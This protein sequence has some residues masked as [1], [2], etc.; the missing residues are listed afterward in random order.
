MSFIPCVPGAHGRGHRQASPAGPTMA[1]AADLSCPVSVTCDSWNFVLY[2][3]SNVGRAAQVH[4]RDRTAQGQ[5]SSTRAL[6][7]TAEHGCQRERA[8][9]TV[10]LALRH[11]FSPD[12]PP[13][14]G[15]AVSSLC[16]PTL[17]SST[18]SLCFPGPRSRDSQASRPPQQGRLWPR[19]CRLVGIWPLG[20]KVPRWVVDI[21]GGGEEVPFEG[22]RPS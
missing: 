21:A 10:L 7:D 22:R 12:D 3:K 2:P 17:S 4:Q 20:F 11:S 18:S 9:K 6:G 5:C 15:A 1:V 14:P 13:P 8:Q 19:E 16:P